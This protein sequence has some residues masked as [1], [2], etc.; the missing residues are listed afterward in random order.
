MTDLNR[1]KK[2]ESALSQKKNEHIFLALKQW[3]NI[4]SKKTNFSK[5]FLDRPSLLTI[6]YKN[7]DLSTNFLNHQF[8]W[9][10]YI[11]AMSGGSSLGY[12]LNDE[13]S[14]I[15]REFDLAMAVGSQSIALKQTDKQT[16]ESFKIVRKNNPN[17]FIFANIGI[18]HNANEAQQAIDMI[19]A[20]VLE[21]HINPVQ[22]LSTSDGDR[23]FSN[24]NETLQDII[25]NIKIPIIIKEVG[26]G[27][28]KNSLLKLDNLNVAAINVAGSGGTDFG[29]IESTRSPNKTWGEQVKN[30]SSNQNSLFTNP[31][32]EILKNARNLNL[33]TPLIANG[34]IASADDVFKSLALG[35]HLVGVAGYFLYLWKNKKLAEEIRNWQTQ[36]PFLYASF[37]AENLNDLHQLN[38]K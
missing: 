4:E 34:G 37:N 20:N 2:I 13:L 33:K 3:K 19:E 30:I 14:K 22:E 12:Q 32:Y 28:S 31:T 21:I 36:L 35:S 38:I 1:N 11:E 7:I 17:G 18:G 29:L 24:W 25:E 23:N 16:I 5:V 6:D 26:F 27:F 15:A 9:P 8:K 10:F